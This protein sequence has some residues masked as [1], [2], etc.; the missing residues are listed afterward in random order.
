M[1]V[2]MSGSPPTASQAMES[3]AGLARSR[4]Y[5]DMK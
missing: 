2:V 1:G 4:Q 3:R 5:S